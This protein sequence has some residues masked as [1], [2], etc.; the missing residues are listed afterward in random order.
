MNESFSEAKEF[1]MGKLIL[2]IVVSGDGFVGGRK[3][4][5]GLDFGDR[6]QGRGEVGGRHALER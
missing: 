3:G 6:E 2:K 1:T 5:S 4:E